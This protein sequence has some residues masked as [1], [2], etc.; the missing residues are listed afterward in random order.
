M[1]RPGTR[2]STV[3]GLA[4][5]MRAYFSGR[6]AGWRHRRA[7]ADVECYCMFVGY[8]SNGHSLVG[9]LLNAHPQVVLAHELD[10]LRY[11]A[12]GFSREQI[13][14]LLLERDRAFVAS[15]TR[16]TGYNYEVPGHWQ[17]RFERLRVIGDKKGG[18]PSL[19]IRA[20]PAVLA[21]LARTVGVRM[22]FVQVVRNPFDNIATMQLRDPHPAGLDYKIDRYFEFCEGVTRALEFA[23]AERS[24]TLRHEDLIADP[25]VSITALCRLVGV[26][27]HEEYL[28]ACRSVVFRSPK[29]ARFEVEWHPHQIE[30]V[31]RHGEAFPFLAGYA[32]HESHAPDGIATTA[33]N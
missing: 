14:G 12:R 28:A 4:E 19:R 7:L 23:G 33:T 3:G 5:D 6:I 24:L 15:G 22:A 27:P 2:A 1:A 31:M 8:P 18:I 16:W 30:R 29:C 10:V 11:V 9:A 25:G 26:E 13:F 21:Q 32:Y 20:R 17:G